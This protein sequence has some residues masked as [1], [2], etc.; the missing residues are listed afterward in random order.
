MQREGRTEERGSRRF[1]I[2]L[3]NSRTEISGEE[4]KKEFKDS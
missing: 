4:K 1:L 2:S 3:R